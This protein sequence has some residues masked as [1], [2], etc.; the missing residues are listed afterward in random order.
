VR[1]FTGAVMP[2][3]AD[4]VVM[5]ER[6]TPTADDVTVAAGAVTRT[7]QNRRLAGEDM[8]RGAVVF[9]AGQPVRPA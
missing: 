9:R 1:I 3:G 4:T 7:G 5:Q 8:K 6:A 2:D